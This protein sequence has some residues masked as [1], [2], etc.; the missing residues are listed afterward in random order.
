MQR[1]FYI[2][3][4]DITG[5]KFTTTGLMVLERNTWRFIGMNL[6]QGNCYGL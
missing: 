3:D 5:E 2:A 4:S 1:A 6:E